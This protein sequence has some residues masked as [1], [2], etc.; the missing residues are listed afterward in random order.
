[1]QTTL[2]PEQVVLFLVLIA[3]GLIAL[4]LIYGYMVYGDEGKAE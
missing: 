4:L 1:M 2:S 3:L